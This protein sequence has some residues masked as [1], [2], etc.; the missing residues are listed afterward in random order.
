MIPGCKNIRQLSFDMI[1]ARACDFPLGPRIIIGN[2]THVQDSGNVA[3]IPLIRHPFHHGVKRPGPFGR[4]AFGIRKDH[5]GSAPGAKWGTGLL[6]ARNTK[7]R[8]QDRNDG[9]PGSAEA[10]AKCLIFSH[11]TP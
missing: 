6:L 3:I 2:V 1:E 9:E 8:K 10:R 5:K 11:I 4:I 7:S